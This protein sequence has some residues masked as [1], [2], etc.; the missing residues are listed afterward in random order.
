MPDLIQ[1]AND[2][3][4]MPDGWL[5]Q[6]MQNPTGSVPPWLVASEVQRRAQLRSGG[7]KAQAPTSSVSQDL[8]RSLYAKIPPTAGLM[9]PGNAPPGMT[10]P[11]LA[12][13]NPGT[14]GSA[15]GQPPN[16]FKT[17]ARTMAEG[18]EFDDTEDDGDSAA[19][20]DPYAPFIQAA[21]TK[22]SIA[23]EVI[24]SMIKTESSGNR[25]A[26]SPKD[27]R[28]LMQVIP[29]TAAIYGVTDPAQL[30]DPATNIDVGTHYLADQLS[31]YKNFSTALAAYNAGPGAVDKYGGIPPFRETRNYVTKNLNTINAARKGLN[32]GPIEQLPANFQSRLLQQAPLSAPATAPTPFVQPSGFLS[33]VVGKAAP[34]APA[35]ETPDPAATTDPGMTSENEADVD[36]AYDTGAAPAAAPP[37]APVKPAPLQ[38]TWQPPKES[39]SMQNIQ[40]QINQM[41]AGHPSV[42]D[43]QAALYQKKNLDMLQ[44]AAQEFFGKPQDYSKYQNAIDQ[45]MQVAQKGLHPSIGDALQQF[46]FALMANKSH[47][48]GVALGEA[49]GAA[50]AAIDKL[51]HQSMQDLL[52][53]A[54]SGIELQSKQDEYNAKIGQYKM[55]RLAAQQTGVMQD[56][57]TWQTQL[58]S[59]QRQYNTAAN[60]Y[61]KKI[62]VPQEQQMAAVAEL[63]RVG[64][65][66]DTALNNPAIQAMRY[67]Q[68]IDVNKILNPGK[69]GK[70]AAGPTTTE[71][72]QEARAVGQLATHMDA[73]GKPMS[74]DPETN[75]DDAKYTGAMDK[76]GKLFPAEKGLPTVSASVMQP[77]EYARAR[78]IAQAIVNGDQDPT[79]TGMYR[80]SPMVREILEKEFHYDLSRARLEYGATQKF[81]ASTNNAAAISYLRSLSFANG[82]IPIVQDAYNKWKQAVTSVAPDFLTRFQGFNKKALDASMAMGGDA[83]AAA[84]QLVSSVTELQSILPGIYSG[85]YAPHTEDLKKAEKML[86]A[87][88]DEK[89]FTGG[90]DLIQSLTKARQNAMKMTVPQFVRENS[91]YLKNMPG[92]ASGQADQQKQQEQQPQQAP[93]LPAMLSPLDVGK[94]F[95]DPKT[96]KKV[97]ILEVHKDDWHKYRYKE[98]Q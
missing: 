39:E 62:Q 46:G 74:W 68:L 34:E 47:Y 6:Q 41:S 35:A 82:Q 66:I 5:A 67:P 30:D 28:G 11:S 19:P 2:L 54:R 4:E 79:L 92:A 90:L 87:D 98:V 60:D 85:G 80:L 18:G 31:K 43:R 22:Y 42:E 37:A 7:A 23:P 91:P 50:S 83:G 69:T 75:P 77:I 56:E 64:I 1:V 12:P 38:Q 36:A 93:P 44:T 33:S 71:K 25:K 59:L 95:L 29:S 51:K 13:S 58:G 10:P 27:A 65:P 49:G 96:G 3:K 81:L 45:V 26:K 14:L 63:N 21:S 48:F 88:W 97:Q 8:I 24:R 17:P 86:G 57:R 73:S 70:G 9:G 94:T 16:S 20:E 76:L 61:Q 53:A 40:E 15:P 78:E 72:T 89:S 52:S 32:L 84:R 55:Q